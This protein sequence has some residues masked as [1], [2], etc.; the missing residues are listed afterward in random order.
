M[1]KPHVSEQ[2]RPAGRLQRG[3]HPS[4]ARGEEFTDD[5]KDRCL[6]PSHEWIVAAFVLDLKANR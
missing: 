5:A 1:W 3:G 6:E 4:S 2:F